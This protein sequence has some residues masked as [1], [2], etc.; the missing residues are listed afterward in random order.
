MI[1]TITHNVTVS[2]LKK[3][4]KTFIIYDKELGFLHKVKVMKN[5]ITLYF[6]QS[7]IIE[8]LTECCCYDTEAD[9]TIAVY[10]FT[11]VIKC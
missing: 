1:P 6:S 9:K 10:L 2:E 11:Q 8:S 3:L 5:S 4:A 7:L